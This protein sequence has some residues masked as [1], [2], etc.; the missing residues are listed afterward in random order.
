MIDN[1]DLHYDLH[2]D[3]LA[4]IL[5]LLYRLYHQSSKQA[6][7]TQ[8]RAVHACMHETAAL[9]MSCAAVYHAMQV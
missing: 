2:H 9:T 3:N 8:A 5:A 7:V 1:H 4:T 6:W